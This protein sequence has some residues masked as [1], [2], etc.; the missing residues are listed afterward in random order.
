MSLVPAGDMIADPFGYAGKR[1]VVTGCGSGIGAAT[2]RLLAEAGAHVHGM[3]L[4]RP[5]LPLAAFSETDLRDRTAI[6]RAAEAIAGPV[7]ALFNCAGL[8]PMAP[9]LE[10]M[11]VNFIGMRHLTEA[12]V[13]RMPAGGAIVTVGSNGGAGWRSR[14]PELLDF[15]GAAGFDDAVR[16]CETHAAPQEG[17]YNFAKEA[18]VAWTMARSAQTI[19]RGIRLNCTSPGSVQTPMLEAIEQV[20]S[21]ERVDLV[22]QPIGRRSRPE[23]QARVLLMLNSAQASYINGVDLPVDGGFVARRT[24]MGVGADEGAIVDRL[25]DA[26]AEG[27]LAAARECFAL[28]AVIWHGFDRIA[29]DLDG[30]AEDWRQLVANFPSRS[31]VDIRRQATATGF[32]QQHVMHVTTRDG[33]RMA[34]PICIVVRIEDGR[35]ARLDEYIDRAGFFVPEAAAPVATPGL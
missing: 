24:A 6:D 2:A 21:A 27:D 23:E 26:L 11:C 32:V 15:I 10:V 16:W 3:D 28:E 25:F 19:A 9:P 5:D 20:V 8:P 17:A 34:W 30:V 4:R 33:R 18:V 13:E 1:V 35:I 29:H 14:L 22:S 7:D 31:F 12:L